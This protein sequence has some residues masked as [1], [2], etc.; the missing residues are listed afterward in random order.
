VP[1]K[2]TIGRASSQTL[3]GMVNVAVKRKQPL[4]LTMSSYPVPCR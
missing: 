4:F 2:R 1:S 3:C